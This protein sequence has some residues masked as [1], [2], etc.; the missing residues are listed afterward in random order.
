[1]KL[2]HV[3]PGCTIMLVAREAF[4]TRHVEILCGPLCTC[5]GDKH[6]GMPKARSLFTIDLPYLLI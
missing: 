1:M 2:D 6:L 4:W 3:V 5:A